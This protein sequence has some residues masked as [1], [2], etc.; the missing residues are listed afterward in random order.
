MYWTMMM[1]LLVSE[2]GDGS[3]RLDASEVARRAA[4]AS[5]SGERAD[6]DV[7]AAKAKADGLDVRF[8][9]RVGLTARYT[10]ISEEDP[11]VIDPGIPGIAPISLGAAQPNQW[12]F[13]LQIA[14]PVSDWFLRSGDV[15][16]AGAR[17]VAAA[18][19]KAESERRR[20][21]LDAVL[22]YWNLVRIGE[23]EKVGA[24][25]IADARARLD[26]T[27]KRVKAAVASTAD[28]RLAEARVAE[29]EG[30]QASLGYARELVSA[31]L[32]V[33]LDL[34]PGTV[35]EVAASDSAA[36]A[37]G[38][39]DEM[40]AEAWRTRPEPRALSEA[41]AA[42]NA[43]LGVQ[44]VARLPRFDVV[45]NAQV[46]NPNPRAF[47]QENEFTP[48]WDV[49]AVVS[50]NVDA[51]W[52]TKPGED[53]VRA[54]IRTLNADRKAL[55]DGIHLEIES[56]LRALRDADTRRTTS[57]AMLAAAEEG[58]R[59]RTKLFAN[60]QATTLEVAEAETQLE[61]ARLGVVDAKIE[62]HIGEARLTY[63][64]GRA[65]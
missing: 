28:L 30:A 47:P 18:G 31:Q 21:A 27:N 33:L 46:V 62:R 25:S 57:E 13:G 42:F 40:V 34:P 59:V 32:R 45:A 1:A 22:V 8:Y 39:L 36:V 14:L 12:F 50:W 3:V 2:P 41:E 49:S 58:H 24:Q 4:V 9:P 51:L 11:A 53:D 48:T 55:D 54:R 19:F 52:T 26:E 38:T 29:T 65:L 64:L 61:R 35:I 20:A 60:G 7:D 17:G 56:A 10:R 16:E 63:A 37:P 5:T 23:A 43:E 15:S 44:N 6:A